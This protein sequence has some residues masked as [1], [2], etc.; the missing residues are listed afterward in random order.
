[1]TKSRA[2]RSRVSRCPAC[3]QRLDEDPPIRCHLC[4]LEFG[5]LRST[6]DDTTPYADTFSREVPGWW[7]M[8]RWIY[9][10]GSMRLKHLGLIRVSMASRHFARVVLLL[11]SFALGA[12]AFTEYG[13]AQARIP[14]M[15]PIASDQMRPSGAGWFP[16]VR[17]S[18]DLVAR[19][20][21]DYVVDLWWNPA[22]AIIASGFSFAIGWI[23]LRLLLFLIRAGVTAAH[24][25]EYRYEL[26]MTAAI[27]YSVAWFV[28]MLL[29][30]CVVAVRPLGFVGQAAD[31]AWLPS[32]DSLEL[33][34][35][36]LAGFGAAMW[37]FWFVRLGVGASPPA[38]GPVTV[39]YALGVP[40]V[41][42]GCTIGWWY[43][44]RYVT[45]VL[46]NG[47]NLNY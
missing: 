16:I 9:F 17:A 31:W 21:S 25:R 26:R 44:L 7:A 19:H 2:A 22:Q 34:A 37:W 46:Y 33:V 35:G 39:F 40:I 3:G 8:C 12:Y 14:L 1:M 45:M 6:S 43:A 30:G 29:A 42:V 28:P 24:R 5:D 4:G 38:R 47:L 20:P 10:A 15:E 13:W 23:A 11:M 36:V 32:D 41:A 18:R 27:K